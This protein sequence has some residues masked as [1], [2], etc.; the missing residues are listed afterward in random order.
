MVE[1]QLYE[2][3]DTSDMFVERPYSIPGI[4][5]FIIMYT[6]VYMRYGACEVKLRYGC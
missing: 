1:T 5:S 6:P 2:L 4:I 3:R